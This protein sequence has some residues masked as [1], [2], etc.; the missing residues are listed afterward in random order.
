MQVDITIVGGGLVGNSLACALQNQPFKM[1]LIDQAP[2]IP[3]KENIDARALALSQSSVRCLQGIGIWKAIA[4]DAA[5]IQKIH[6]SKQGCFGITQLVGEPELPLGYVVNADRLAKVFNK[7]VEQLSTLEIFKPD[8]IVEL[9]RIK[10]AW[11]LRLQSGSILVTKLLVA[12]D[13]THS[14]LRKLQGMGVTIDDQHQIALVVNVKCSESPHQVA[15]ERFTQQGS[16]AM[17]PFKEWVKCVWIVPTTTR[18]LMENMPEDEFLQHLQDA[19]GYRLGYL[20]KAGKRITYS[21]QTVVANSLY[22]QGLVLMGNAANTLHPVAAQGF[23]MGLRDVATLAEVLVA[24][25]QEKEAIGSV[26]VL[27]RYADLRKIDH[28]AIR[29]L[30]RQLAAPTIIQWLGIVACEWALPFKRFIRDWG[31]GRH[32]Y[33]PKL[34]RGIGLS[35]EE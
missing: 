4:A 29:Q 10:D 28:H 27:R 30:C 15:Y 18:T 3:I 24:A 13:G 9:K 14:P 20:L 19:F 8:T 22:D 34:C 31:M 17:L 6:V 7:T 1:A 2:V 25:R 23:N 33:L 32:Q 11:Q 21:L 12:A 16:I 26:E 35:S 5:P